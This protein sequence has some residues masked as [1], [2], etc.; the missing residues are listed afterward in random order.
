M[1]LRISKNVYVDKTVLISD[2]ISKFQLKPLDY[3]EA[4]K[5]T[6]IKDVKTNEKLSILGLNSKNPVYCKGERRKC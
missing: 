3:V 1:R 4:P 2:K 5:N 6:P